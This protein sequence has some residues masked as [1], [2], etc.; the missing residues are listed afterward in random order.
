VTAFNAFLYP[1][2]NGKELEVYCK[3]K[4]LKVSE[5]ILKNEQSQK[6]NEDIDIELSRIWDTMLE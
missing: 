2:Q 3:N 4:N 5:I 6:K 1:T